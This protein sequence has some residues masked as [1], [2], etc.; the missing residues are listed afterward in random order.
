[1]MG[2][3]TA[4][5]LLSLVGFCCVD[6]VKT[7]NSGRKDC[8]YGDDTF[9]HGAVVLSLPKICMQLVCNHGKVERRYLETPGDRNCCE[10]D[11]QMYPQ[12][13]EL[14]AHCITMTCKNTC[15]EPMD[16]IDDCCNVCSLDNDPHMITF[17]DYKYEWHGT[18]N[19]SLAQSDSTEFP[20][21][22]V[23]GDFRPCNR[24]ASCLDICTFKNDEHTVITL[25]HSS[26]FDILV[27]GDPYHVKPGK[28]Q[29]VKSSHGCHPVLVW[30][31]SF[32][33]IRLLGSSRLMIQHCKNTMQIWAHPYHT[34]NLDGLCGHFNFYMEDDFTNRNGQVHNLVKWPQAFPYSW[35]TNT[36]MDRICSRHCPKCRE[37]TTENP[38]DATS[39]QWRR[40]M[41]MCEKKLLKAIG[42]R[43]E[44][45]NRIENCAFDLCMM[46]QSG[47]RLE[48]LQRWLHELLELIKILAEIW[49]N[50]KVGGR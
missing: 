15:W 41:D 36:Q 43:T 25:T 20:E 32:R 3:T 27:N 19:Y 50:T 46:E 10:F 8:C 7:V 17:D 39:L 21:I 42:H 12:G 5:L 33:C 38:C 18:C 23:F 2:L 14:S 40:Y 37:E 13:A 1:M 34:D 9:P 44:L 22:G 4:F 47:E 29:A 45:K 11:G 26:V 49:D 48:E 30:R 31:I 6:L 35:L 16:E 28:V 24:K